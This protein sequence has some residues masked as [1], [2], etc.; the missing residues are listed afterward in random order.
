MATTPAVLGPNTRLNNFRL[1]YLTADQ[2]AER[3]TR[4]RIILGG[5]DIT[6][7]T[8]PMRVTYQSMTIRDLLFDAPNTC[9]FTLYGSAVPTI[10]Q[11]I[12][13][14]INANVP[15]LLFS[16]ELQTVER[17]YKGQP[18]TVLHPV[19]AIDDTAK[20][21][22]KRPLQPYVNWSASKIAL[23]LLERYA[24][25]FSP[26][27][28][29]LDLP[30]VSIT[31]D[32]SE[33]GMKGCL[34]ALAKLIGAYWY[35][36]NN[37]LFFFVTPTGPS[38]DPIDDTPHRFLHDPAITWAI[39]KS[40]VRT[41]VYGKG[42]RTEVTTTV[43]AG[44]GLL[45]VREATMFNPAGGQAV[46]GLTP[47]G[48]TCRVLSYYAVQLGG[49]GGLVGPGAAPSAPPGLV[50]QNGAGM[51]TGIHAYAVTFTTAAGESLAGPSATI[52]VGVTPPPTLTVQPGAPSAGGAVDA[53]R[54][55]YAS[56]FVTAVGETPSAGAGP[57]VVTTVGTSVPNPG[58]SSATLR[59]VVGNLAVGVS[60]K[61]EATITTASGETLPGPASPTWITPEAPVGPA[62]VA[63]TVQFESGGALLPG[64]FYEYALSGVV[65][66]YETA[67]CP[68]FG[69][70]IPN[71]PLLT[72]IVLGYVAVSADARITARKLYRW[73]NFEWRLVATIPDNLPNLFYRDGT[74]D[75]SLGPARVGTGTIGTP[76]GD[77]ALVTIPTSADGRAVGR[78]IYR[79]DNGAAFRY[80]ATVSNNSATQ[81]IDNTASVA[82]N[83]GDPTSNTTGGTSYQTVPLSGIQVGPANVTARKIYR[84]R[85]DIGWRLLT[86]IGN[87]TATTFTDTLATAGLTVATP[88]STNTATANQVG[89]TL[90]L[91][92][93]T[94][95]GRKLYRSA[96]NQTPLKLV[97]TIANNTTTT[98]ADAAADATLGAAPPATD[99]SG[100]TQPAGQVPA[101]SPSIL[102]ANPAPFDASGGWAVVGNGEQVIRYG[103]KSATA[104][105]GITPSG[106]GALVASVAYNST[107]TAA[108]ALWL[109]S[110][111][112]DA[113]LQG[114]P[115]QV[116]VQRDDP[117]A[118]TYMAALDGGGDGIYEHIWSDE[119]RSEASL[120]QV[121]DAQLALYSR[122]LVTVTYASRDLKTKSG[123]KV[124]IAIATPPITE[125]L[126]IQDVTITELG[127]TGLA[128]KFTVTASTVHQSFEAVLRMLMRKAEA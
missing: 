95:T 8:S 45:P 94:V 125:T 37:T 106:P 22:R 114:A 119:R 56:T 73:F 59:H 110:A 23:D 27:G 39:D 11:P 72:R 20:A 4:I 52:T 71:D 33:A 108:P 85:S 118:Q 78:K 25:T 104:L 82:A 14:W 1:N 38:P 60:Y 17:T 109:V 70:T 6:Q 77:Q 61:Y 83:A 63:Q 69:V 113:V 103:G 74:S 57:E 42:A 98:I 126:T 58:G 84:F 89:V 90:P 120:R 121:C 91:G 40:Q 116:W 128:P 55:Q 50:A 47:D 62:Y 9:A 19:T 29:E 24:P 101:G 30:A 46:L 96:A 127:I 117:A 86:T 112:P 102:V 99:T 44:T 115:I 16:G 107:I 67:L 36:E 21:N 80:L 3:P 92:G 97:A 87:N 124:Q 79:S 41:R 65:G 54:Y 75:A 76:P 81:Y 32:G 51:E 105:T 111:I 34:T 10:G 53:G 5:I 66:G 7:P 26:A 15:Q 123:R 49:G 2:A 12:A 13:V 43:D 48:A 18:T 35:F 100:L 28:I 68:A 93:T 122:P 88:P 31:F 64:H